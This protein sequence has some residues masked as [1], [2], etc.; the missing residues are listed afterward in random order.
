[1][2]LSI[3]EPERLSYFMRG[4]KPAIRGY[5]LRTAPENFAD[6]VSQ[7]KLYEAT[8]DLTPSPPTAAA[9]VAAINEVGMRPQ[10][11]PEMEYPEPKKDRLESLVES[12]SLEMRTMMN[13]LDYLVNDT[14]GQS[15]YQEPVYPR[16]NDFERDVPEMNETGSHCWCYDCN[17]DARVVCDCQ[18][19]QYQNEFEQQYN[20]LNLN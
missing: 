10:H 1:M 11:W 5:V 7:A 15:P 12:L 18:D 19:I 3:S 20:E 2:A 17:S 9:I 6:A 8:A 13:E 16:I 4:L 14:V